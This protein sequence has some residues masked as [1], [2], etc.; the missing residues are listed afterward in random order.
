MEQKYFNSINWKRV[1][2]VNNKI[3]KISNQNQVAFL[4][5]MNIFCNLDS[6]RCKV[7]HND[8]KIH[9][10]NSGHTTFEANS[11]LSKKL[12]ESTDILKILDIQ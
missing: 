3:E 9:T 1:N 4:D 11:F 8:I 7:L 10:D 5:D 2:D 12:I 6:K